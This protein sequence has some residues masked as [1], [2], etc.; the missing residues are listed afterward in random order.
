MAHVSTQITTEFN[1]HQQDLAIMRVQQVQILENQDKSILTSIRHHEREG[2][3]W[4]KVLEASQMSYEAHRETRKQ[5]IDGNQKVIDELSTKLESLP[6]SIAGLFAE[7]KKSNRKIW[8]VGERREG[9]LTPRLIPKD[10]MRSSLETVSHHADLVSQ[11]HI[12]WLQSEFE[13]SPFPTL[14]G[15]LIRQMAVFSKS[16]RNF[17]K[18]R[19]G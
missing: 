16:A 12:Y 13:C 10:H 2:E 19:A 1:T 3:N 4:K 8:M 5:I 18:R 14:H 17:E 6:E 15:N 9:I 7:A 11:E